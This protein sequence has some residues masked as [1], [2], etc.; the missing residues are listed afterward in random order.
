MQADR[1]QRSM[2]TS[3]YSVGMSRLDHAPTSNLILSRV[4]P[5]VRVLVLHGP[6]VTALDTLTRALDVSSYT[7][8]ASAPRR[9]VQVLLLFTTYTMLT[10]RCLPSLPL[11]AMP[12]HLE[13]LIHRVKQGI[14]AV[15]L[16]HTPHDRWPLPKHHSDPRRRL[17]ISVLDSSF[18]PPTL[19]HLALAS[20]PASAHVSHPNAAGT[21][22]DVAGLDARLLLLSVRNADKSLKPNDATYAQRLEMMI[23]LAQDVSSPQAQKSLADAQSDFATYENLL[24]DPNVA[25]A[26]I[27][28]PTFVGKS[29]VLHEWLR[30]RLASLAFGQSVATSVS[31]SRPELTF[32]VG[33]DTLERILAVRYY[34][35]SEENMRQSLKQF[36]SADEDDSRLVCARRVTPGSLESAEDRERRVS[37]LVRGYIEPDRVVMVDIG[38]KVESYSSSEVRERIAHSDTIWTQMVAPSIADYIQRQH[39]YLP[40]DAQH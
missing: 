40:S 26:I 20:V 28:E 37:R 9:N 25:V 4:F 7:G 27:D 8:L 6:S 36:L 24:S 2:S 21:P 11:L 1:L 29:R 3:K 34:G 12:S 10:L 14:S 38:E 39:L 18:N 23:L 30:N 32:L 22:H 17:R 15:E 16:V 35:E 13:G 33:I 5:R 31:A 19:A